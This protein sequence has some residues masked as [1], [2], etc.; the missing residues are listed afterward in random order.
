MYR[1]VLLRRQLLSSAVDGPVY[2][3]FC[4]D[5]DVAAEVYPTR[6]H[7]GADLDPARV[8][9]AAGR[10][11]YST[12]RVA[13]CDAWPFEGEQLEARF[14]VADLDAYVNPYPSLVAFWSN[15]K[16]APRVVIFGTD[17]MRLGFRT[18]RMSRKRGPLPEGTMTA[19]PINEARAQYNAWWSRIAL[20][21][22]KAT[23]AP[24]HVI[25]TMQYLRDAQLYWGAVVAEP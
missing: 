1:K 16:K 23:V 17:G 7:Y 4:G 3:P 6:V 11:P 2:L 21:F 5:G 22:V 8:A 25:R 13:D 9:T 12:F 15:A 20:P 19:A 10:F 24:W 18:A 14:A